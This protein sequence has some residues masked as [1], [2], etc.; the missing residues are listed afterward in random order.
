MLR[1][2][3]AVIV[4]GAGLYIVFGEHLAGVSSDATVNA[5]LTTL[6]SPIDGEVNF[7]LDKIGTVLQAGEHIGGIHN[8][9]VD[10]TRLSDLQDRHARLISDIGK[11]EGQI[12]STKAARE[13]LDKQ[14]ATYK[15]GRLDQLGA[16]IDEGEAQIEAARA[17]Q[18]KARHSLKRARVLKERGVQ[19]IARL[20]E[21]ESQFQVALKDTEAAKKRKAFLEVELKAAKQGTFLGDSYNDTPY[22]WQRLKQL[23]LELDKLQAELE[24]LKRRKKQTQTLIDG[25]R[26]RLAEL[27]RAKIISPVN[28]IVWDFLAGSGESVQE[29][30]ELLRVVDCDTV[31]VTANVSERL[32]NELQPG[33]TARFR[34]LGEDTSYEVTVSRLAGAGANQRYRTLAIAAIPEEEIGYDVLLDVSQIAANDGVGCMVGQKGRVVFSDAPVATLQKFKVLLGL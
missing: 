12:A 31:V 22:S 16:K 28:G 29:G 10:T 27:S 19:S 26:V 8:T 15:Q 17:R 21:A 6:R 7:D 25:E 20:D 23:N 32:Y 34:V 18:R 4:L 13:G 2:V 5:R 24:S 9:R 33:D 1:I 3:I 14:I 30:Q 11:I